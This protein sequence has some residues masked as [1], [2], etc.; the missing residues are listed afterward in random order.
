MTMAVCFRCGGMKFGAFVP[1]PECRQAPRTEED[2]AISMAMTDHYFDVPTLKKIGASVKKGKP[3]KLSPET[4]A[5]LI[6]QIRGSGML[7]RIQE[8]FPDSPTESA[9]PQ[10]ERPAPRKPWWRFW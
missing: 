7:E 4:K 5:Q 3:P 8:M 9:S 2:L 10:V 6:E 1:C